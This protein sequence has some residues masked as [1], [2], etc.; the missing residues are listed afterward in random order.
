MVHIEVRSGD[1]DSKCAC[2]LS[3]LEGVANFS[4]RYFVNFRI[5]P[6]PCWLTSTTIGEFIKSGSTFK[7]IVMPKA[8]I[9]FCMYHQMCYKGIKNSTEA[10]YEITMV[11]TNTVVQ[12][13]V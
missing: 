4:P 1:I 13:P 9:F 8:C 3:L 5:I 2:V 6:E 12:G 10:M 7:S 11:L